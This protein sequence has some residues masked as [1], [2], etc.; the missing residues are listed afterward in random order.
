MVLRKKN[1]INS[2]RFIFKS[3]ANAALEGTPET[4]GYGLS[5]AAVHQLIK[6]LGS[7]KSGLPRGSLCV[8]LLP[9]TLDTVV[10]RHSMPDADIS[11]WTPTKYIVDLLYKWS[12][13]K[14]RPKN[15]SLVRFVTRNFN[16]DVSYL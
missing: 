16:T 2:R 9:V 15:G 6:S 1:T 12:L 8:G 3:G 13:G 5:K 11:G 10:N 7:G 4:I 14:E